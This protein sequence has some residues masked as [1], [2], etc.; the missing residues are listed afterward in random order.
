MQVQAQAGLARSQLLFSLLHSLCTVSANRCVISYDHILPG[1][2]RPYHPVTHENSSILRQRKVERS[3][4]SVLPQDVAV[5]WRWQSEQ[6]A[7]ALWEGLLA[8]S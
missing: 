8:L 7:L 5:R 3:E 2:Q 6:P 4:F 1:M